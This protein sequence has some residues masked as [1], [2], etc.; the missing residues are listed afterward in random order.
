VGA[1]FLP[2]SLD[3]DSFVL[4]IVKVLPCTVLYYPA[5]YCTVLYCTV[6]FFTLVCC[7]GYTN[8]VLY[9]TVL[10]CTVLFV[11]ELDAV[12]H[13]PFCLVY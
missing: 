12:M 10:Y 11:Q 2:R 1:H 5:L 6:R 7:Q 13:R 8:T 9:C 4:Y 3:L